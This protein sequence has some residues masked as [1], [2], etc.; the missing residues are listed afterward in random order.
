MVTVQSDLDIT[1]CSTV[2][3]KLVGEAYNLNLS[4][5]CLRFN[6]QVTLELYN[7]KVVLDLVNSVEPITMLLR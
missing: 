4:S 5:E 6:I 3:V 7:K 1:S 2:T